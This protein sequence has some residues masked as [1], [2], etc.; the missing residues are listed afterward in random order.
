MFVQCYRSKIIIT[1]Q[2]Y[3]LFFLENKKI[4][5]F[6]KYSVF[7]QIPIGRYERKRIRAT[8]AL[9]LNRNRLDRIGVKTVLQVYNG[10]IEVCYYRSNIVIITVVLTPI[11]A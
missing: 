5:R 9:E 6:E 11:T 3:I 4:C 8:Y 10:I 7:Y 2:F 1:K